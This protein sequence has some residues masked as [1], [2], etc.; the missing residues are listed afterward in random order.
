MAA[1]EKGPPAPEKEPASPAKAEPTEPPA[2]AEAPKEEAAPAESAPTPKKSDRRE[3][4]PRAKPAKKAAKVRAPRRPELDPELRRLLTIRTDGDRRRPL[5][6]R[7]AS[8]RYWR[9]G[10]WESWRKPKGQQSKQR[11]HYGYRPTIVSIGFGSPRRT[12][13]LTPTGFRPQLVHTTEEIDRLDAKREA[14]LI[15]RTVGTRKRLV[16]EERARERGIH[17]LNPLLHEREDT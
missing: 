7:T 3:R 6:V 9:I 12:R 15:A 11:R 8:H 13:G 5:F 2:A 4:K 1:E 17:V 16:L 14:A 10:R